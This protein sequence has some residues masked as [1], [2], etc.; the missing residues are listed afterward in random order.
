ML[1]FKQGIFFQSNLKTSSL[2]SRCIDYLALKLTGLKVSGFYA[3]IDALKVQVAA[4]QKKTDAEQVKLDAMSSRVDHLTEKVITD[5]RWD[6]KAG[7]EELRVN[8]EHLSNTEDH[9]QGM[10][11]RAVVS[12]LSAAQHIKL[13]RAVN[14]SRKGE[15]VKNQLVILKAL[16]LN[17]KKNK[18]LYALLSS[19]AFSKPEHNRLKLGEKDSAIQKLLLLLKSF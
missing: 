10:K 19:A 14:S 17:R 8:Q 6:L 12:R 16:K 9:V 18:A 4:A 1:T 11:C 13:A 7:E 5:L 3:E 2:L 15:P